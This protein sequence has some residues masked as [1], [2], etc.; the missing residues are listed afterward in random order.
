M[1]WLITLSKPSLKSPIC[2]A[3]DEVVLYFEKIND[4]SKQHTTVNFAKVIYSAKNIVSIYTLGNLQK[5]TIIR[6]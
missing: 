5:F 1:K 3:Q 2:E 4:S 6:N